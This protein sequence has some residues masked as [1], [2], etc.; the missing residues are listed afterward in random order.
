MPVSQRYSVRPAVHRDL[1]GIWSYIRDRSGYPERASNFVRELEACFQT[2]ANTPTIGKNYSDI[3]PGL[4]GY[5]HRRYVIFYLISD[6]GADIV[7][8]IFGGRDLERALRPPMD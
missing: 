5:T 7:R 3:F 2:I 6:D 4:Y 1:A 8:V